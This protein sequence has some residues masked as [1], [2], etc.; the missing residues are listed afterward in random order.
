MGDRIIAA[1]VILIAGTAIVAAILS[2]LGV[3]LG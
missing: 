3:D 1:L 2:L